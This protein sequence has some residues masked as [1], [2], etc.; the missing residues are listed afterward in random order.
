MN[1]LGVSW[2]GDEYDLSTWQGWLM[3][4]IGLMLWTFVSSLTRKSTTTSSSQQ[5]KDSPDE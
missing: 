5:K 2:R 3:L 1:I 4:A